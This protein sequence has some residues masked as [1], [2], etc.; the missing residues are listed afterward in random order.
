MTRRSAAP[1][2][3]ELWSQRLRCQG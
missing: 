1:C 2:S 3:D